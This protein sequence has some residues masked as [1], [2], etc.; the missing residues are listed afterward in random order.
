ML[1]TVPPERTPT[2]PQAPAAAPA[3]GR[4]CTG[5]LDVAVSGAPP[6]RRRYRRL[7]SSGALAARPTPTGLYLVGAGA[8][9]IGGDELEVRLAL[10]AGA[11]LE[12]RSAAA[13]L[14]R[15]GE[16]GAPSI[17]RTEI[18]L[19]N[20]AAL[21]WL[22]QPGIAAAGASHLSKT[23]IV[24]SPTSR[25]A[26]REE[27]VLG[28]HGEV[29]PGSWS[30]RLEVLVGERPLL[31]AELGLGPAAP[32]W[33]LP[34]VLGG[35][36]ALSTLLVV[37]PPWGKSPPACRLDSTGSGRA[38]LLPLEGPCVQVLAWGD[39]LGSCRL[40]LG[41]LLEPFAECPPWQEARS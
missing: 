7:E 26:W 24:L 22:P 14:A 34:T 19:A 39:D 40:L 16:T 28:R 25:L 8:Q 6:N 32:A 15:R 5:L 17:M 9:P 12:V 3:H 30:S 29:E 37:H 4:S 41:R 10:D 2:P 36:R 13:T 38:M 35:A 11:E 31:V 1:R 23:R 20:G 18:T 27:I 21:R 33:R